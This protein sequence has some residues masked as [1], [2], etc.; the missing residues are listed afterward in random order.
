[1]DSNK[2][3]TIWSKGFIFIIIANASMS[4]A[5]FSINTYVATYMDYL[6]MGPVLIGL[7]AGLFYGMAFFMRPVS[8]PAVTML[9]RKKL[10]I[11]VYGSAIFINLGYA[12]FP[13]VPIFVTMRLLH[14]VQLSFYGSVALTIATE[15]LPE[16]KMASGLGFYGLTYIVAQAIGPALA[17]SL[18]AFGDTHFGDGGGFMAIFLAAAFFATLSTIPCMLLPYKAPPKDAVKSLG[19]WYKNIVAFEAIVP[20]GVMML[21]SMAM[22]LLNTYMIPYGVWRGIDNIAIYF[23]VTAVVTVVVR[24]LAGKLTDRVGPAKVFFPGTALSMTSFILISRAT[25][26]RFIVLAAILASAG[27]GTVFPA[28]QAMTMQSV[29]TIRRG[30]ASNTNF[31]AMDLG[32]FIGPSLSGLII[33]RFNYSIM[34]AGLLVP[35]TLAMIIFALGWKPY[36]RQRQRLAKEEVVHR[37]HSHRNK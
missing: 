26:L 22:V 9:N 27:V 14:G 16:D 11:I 18:Q 29:P 28:L 15:F 8:G 20:A 33:S 17:A 32:N 5:Q 3:T 30:V 13:S 6:G 7:I 1:M 25:D 35:L 4:L 10:M 23:T 12:F 19:P 37:V 21:L 36:N 31:L 2:T 34:Y 24:P